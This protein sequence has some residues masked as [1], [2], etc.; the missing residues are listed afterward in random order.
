[1]YTRSP[2]LTTA[3]YKALATEHI[4]LSVNIGFVF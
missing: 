4:S 1:M 3:M 2:V